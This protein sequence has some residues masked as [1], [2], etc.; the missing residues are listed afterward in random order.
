MIPHLSKMIVDMSNMIESNLQAQ[1]KLS[2]IRFSV[3]V[4]NKE[5]SDS[6]L[7]AQ[8]EMQKVKGLEKAS[9]S[10]SK[11]MKP[12]S[13]KSSSLLSKIQMNLTKMVKTLKLPHEC[14]TIA[15]VY[16]SRAVSRMQS[17]S[18][19]LSNATSEK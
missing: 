5:L 12:S 16:V 10:P 19:F 11:S 3:F 2:D 6:K 18:F 17:K 15:W 14:L 8:L 4:N 13:N 7:Q 1:V 9:S